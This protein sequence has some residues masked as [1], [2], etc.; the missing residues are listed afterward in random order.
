MFNLRIKD[1]SAIKPLQCLSLLLLVFSPIAL[2]DEVDEQKN[3][4]IQFNLPVNDDENV[5][6]Q[7]EKKYA[8]TI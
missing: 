1:Y 5:I 7:E 8:L 2:G 4:I 3:Q 6:M